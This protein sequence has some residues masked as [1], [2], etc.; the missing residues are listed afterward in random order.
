M[1]TR[2]HTGPH[3][4]GTVSLFEVDK[5]L[6]SAPS[7]PSIMDDTDASRP[8]SRALAIQGRETVKRI[9]TSL[10]QFMFTFGTGVAVYAQGIK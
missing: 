2:V 6:K 1:R 8:L 4:Q 7:S 10:L 5:A 9:M 3:G